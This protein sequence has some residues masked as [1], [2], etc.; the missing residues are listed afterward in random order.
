[1]IT[2]RADCGAARFAA[3]KM[4]PLHHFAGDFRSPDV[5][6][7]CLTALRA[8]AVDLVVP[9]GFLRPVGPAVLAAFGP[10]VTMSKPWRPE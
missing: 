5:D 9:A 4:L 10:R 3:E 7:A 6:R 2:N 8:G 1:M